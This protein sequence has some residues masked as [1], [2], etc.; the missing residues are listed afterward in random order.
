MTFSP[1]SIAPL[2]KSIVAAT[3]AR[4]ERLARLRR[5]PG[6]VA[7]EGAARLMLDPR[8]DSL[9]A[10]QQL[11]DFPHVARAGARRHLDRQP[12][13]QLR[14]Q[15][16]DIVLRS[17]Q[18]D[19]VQLHRQ[20]VE[21]RRAV[22][23]PAVVVLLGRAIALREREEAAAERVADQLQQ[24]EQVARPVGQRRAGQQVDR[25]LPAACD[26]ARSA[27]LPRQLAA[28]AGV[29]LQV[30]RLVEDE[31]GPGHAS[32]GRRRASTGCRS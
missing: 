22:G 24:H 2:T 13:P 16:Q 4:R 10:D 12:R 18:H 30:V 15:R 32:R 7:P 1:C 11:H 20:L 28:R 6:A 26:F 19:A 29:V 3:F 9:A 27:R 14:R 23:L 31:P 5:R 21:V 8:R 17:A 25:R